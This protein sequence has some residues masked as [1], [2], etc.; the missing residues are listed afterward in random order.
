MNA[1]VTVTRIS[2]RAI[3][4]APPAL[5]WTTLRDFSNVA[6]WHPDVKDCLMKGGEP[7]DRV[8]A[9]RAIH[10][11][12]GMALRER[13]TAISD[14][15]MSYSYSVIESPFPLAYHSSSVSLVA[16]DQGTKTLVTWDVE[17]SLTEGDPEQMAKAIHSSVILPGFGGL[18]RLAARSF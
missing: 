15:D 1:P 4:E 12:N 7:G 18:A 8:G 17:F 13:V 11:G 6:L 3:I 14:K 2:D 16:V 5:I 9:V 10:L